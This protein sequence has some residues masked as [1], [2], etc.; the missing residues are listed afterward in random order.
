[1][2]SQPSAPAT[3]PAPLLNVAN[4]LTMVRIALV[5]VLVVVFMHDAATSPPWRLAATGVFLLA[6]LTDRYDGK[7]A[8]SRGLITD[9]GKIADPIADKALIG[10]ALVCLSW[11][12][13][14]SWWVTGVILGREL[15]VTLIR[16]AVIRYEV[17]AASKGGKLKTVTQIIAISGYLLPAEWINR[18]PVLPT[19]I[20]IAMI[21]AVAITVATGADYA[22]Q[23]AG[24]VRRAKRAAP[25][26]AP[27]QPAPPESAP[28]TAAPPESTPATAG[29][30]ESA[31]AKLAPSAP[32]TAGPASA[33]VQATAPNPTPTKPAPP[34]AQP[35][36]VGLAPSAPAPVGSGSMTPASG[37]RA[38]PPTPGGLTPA[39]AA[40][41]VPATGQY[42]AGGAPPAGPGAAL[43][44]A[45]AEAQVGRP[46][47]I[48]W[49]PPTRREPAPVAQAAPDK[50]SPPTAPAGAGLVRPAPF[51]ISQP[52]APRPP[53][54]VA[55]AGSV[56][57]GSAGAGASG[58]GSAGA[59]ASGAGSAGPGLARAGSGAPG[60]GGTGSVSGGSASGGFVGAGGGG[61][62]G[63]AGVPQVGPD[64][65]VK[66][67]RP[68]AG[69]PDPPQTRPAPAVRPA[70]PRPRPAAPEWRQLRTVIRAAEIDSGGEA[71]QTRPAQPGARSAPA[72]PGA[73]SAPAPPRPGSASAQ[74]GTHPSST[75]AAYAHP[76]P[77]PAYQGG[78]K[79]GG[80]GTASDNGRSAAIQDEALAAAQ[81]RL[82]ELK[83]RIGWGE[84]VGGPSRPAT[85][86]RET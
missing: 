14:L 16:M 41:A 33:A 80:G 7:L 81:A 57:A 67:T 20:V 56:S 4:V 10:A 71:P 54:G 78:R 29:P 12:G 26:S 39:A 32:A 40:P 73:R 31:R 51:S 28:A 9:F 66:P 18:V 69:W 8:R 79:L 72:Q 68:V 6:S 30:P 27:V 43:S 59:G 52:P 5:P 2:T 24:I 22:I 44:S 17:I 53:V 13:L 34:A 75:T 74:T 63:G 47:R 83:R 49:V 55:G 15:A 84:E 85:D 37:M 23:A 45:G 62:P 42:L 76:A 38:A 64:E 3:A 19:L 46:R 82:T 48:E 61:A 60:A 35:T 1:M 36:P 11:V 70:P 58:A 50:T 25:E 77:A 65:S 86:D 21:L